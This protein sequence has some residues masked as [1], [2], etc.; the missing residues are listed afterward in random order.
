MRHLGQQW[1]LFRCLTALLDATA[2]PSEKDQ[3][4]APSAK[5]RSVGREGA[6]DHPPG[7]VGPGKVVVVV[8]VVVV[9]TGLRIAYG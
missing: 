5:V 3:S 6:A 8:V 7:D 4:A 9:V 1:H 2:R